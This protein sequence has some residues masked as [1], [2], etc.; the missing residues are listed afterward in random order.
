VTIAVTEL[1]DKHVI[2][3]TVGREVRRAVNEQL[4]AHGLIEEARHGNS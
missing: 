2:S 4:R 1:V 3:F